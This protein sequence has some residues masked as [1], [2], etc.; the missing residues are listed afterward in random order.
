[1]AE[2]LL[3]E[4]GLEEEVEDKW[5]EEEEEEEKEEDLREE[6]LFQRV[7]WHLRMQDWCVP[8]N[9]PMPSRHARRV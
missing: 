8:D 7:V 5:G 4:L 3:S 1:M 9:L 2:L 6:F